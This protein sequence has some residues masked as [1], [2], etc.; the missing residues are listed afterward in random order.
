MEIWVWVWESVVAE[1]WRRDQEPDRG[2]RRDE[3]ADSRRK[4]DKTGET[5]GKTRKYRDGGD[6][7]EVEA[8][9]EDVSGWVKPTGTAQ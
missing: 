9:G 3:A 2:L 8:E 4:Y 7:G 5:R 6:D 1:R